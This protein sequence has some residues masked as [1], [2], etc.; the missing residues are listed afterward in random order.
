MIGDSRLDPTADQTWNDDSKRINR[1]QCNFVDDDDHRNRMDNLGL[2]YATLV[3]WKRQM[4][5]F[6]V[7]H[8][9]DWWFFQRNHLSLGSHSQPM[10]NRHVA[11]MQRPHVM[12]KMVEDVDQ[13]LWLVA[14]L[15]FGK[16][17]VEWVD[18]FFHKNHEYKAVVALRPP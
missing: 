10:K 4:P 13:H 9:V 6:V 17:L 3:D 14:V 8:A 15:S 16:T 5:V 1:M 11:H 18:G 7:E 12:H 2:A